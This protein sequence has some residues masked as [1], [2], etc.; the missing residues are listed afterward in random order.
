MVEAV[1]TLP[2][3]FMLLFGMITGG[4]ALGQKNAIE[5]SAREASRFGATLEVI[6]S[7]DDWLD[8]V[9]AVAIEAASGELAPGTPGRYVCVALVGTSNGA[10]GGKEITGDIESP[11]TGSCK[12]HPDDSTTMSCPTNRPCVQVALARDT[13]LDLVATTRS[14]TLQASSVN[15][16]ERT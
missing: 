11:L 15:T 14:L 12:R 7:T 16:F 2:L 9:A 8:D 13:T 10:D 3:V 4:I 1:L 6:T 5:N